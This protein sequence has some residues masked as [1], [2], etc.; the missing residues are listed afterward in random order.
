MPPF[1]R[2]NFDEF[3][4]LIAPLEIEKVTRE[5]TSLDEAVVACPGVASLFEKTKL[6]L[7]SNPSAYFVRHANARL[8]TEKAFPALANILYQD[9]D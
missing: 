6:E 1:E 9:E 8:A 4:A 5:L 2:S 3:D 7:L